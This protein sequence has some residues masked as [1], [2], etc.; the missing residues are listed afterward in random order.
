[1]TGNS[2]SE[3]EA[4]TKALQLAAANFNARVHEPNDGARA[5]GAQ[6]RSGASSDDDVVDADFEEVDDKDHQRHG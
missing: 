1:M 4:K 6:A 3:I 5:Q 2:E